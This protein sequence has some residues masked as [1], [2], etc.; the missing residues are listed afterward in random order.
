MHEVDT[1]PRH[2]G[3]EGGKQDDHRGETFQHGPEEDEQHRGEHE[4]HDIAAGHREHGSE[5]ELRYL[6]YR[7][8][9]RHHRRRPEQEAH[10]RRHHRALDEESGQIAPL[11]L[12]VDEEPH[13][14]G[15][16]HREHR[17]L[18]RRHR[19]AQDAAEDDGGQPQRNDGVEK[20]VADGGPRHVGA[21]LDA[22]P[23]GVEPDIDHDGEGDDHG[24]E[25]ARGEEGGHRDVGHGGN[26][27]HENAG[28]HENAH[29]R[30]GRDH[31]HRLLLAVARLEHGRDHGRADGRDVGHRGAR[32]AGE[33][34]LGHHHGHAEASAN[35]ADQHLGEPDQPHRDA[36]RLHEGAR[37]DK[38]G[39][40]EQDEGVNAFEGL[41]HDDGERVLPRP[42]ETDEA[43]HPDDEGH[44]HAEGEQD[45][46]RDGSQDDHQCPCT[47]VGAPVTARQRCRRL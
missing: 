5:E 18:R 30:G 45:Q 26:D 6:L 27:D 15:V 13:D 32:D 20:G 7:E 42:P 8:H 3:H 34:V 22:T 4:E 33:D 43:R 14:E 23:P 47:A 41:L 39:N 1:Q 46:K 40:G 24:G 19:A 12:A 28:R 38:E 37:Q 29:G 9:P 11:D 17:G 25:K 44:G 10:R 21:C 31:R 16:H 2:H 35:P 36:P